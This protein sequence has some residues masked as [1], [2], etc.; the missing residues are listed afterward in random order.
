MI[1][2]AEEGRRTAVVL[3]E[4]KE[5][6]RRDRCRNRSGARSFSLKSSKLE[7]LPTPLFR[8][9]LETKWIETEIKKRDFNSTSNRL[10]GSNNLGNGLV[11]RV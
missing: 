7:N 9:C 5:R 10:G 11:S 2:I 8:P 4:V 3:A 6:N 1:I